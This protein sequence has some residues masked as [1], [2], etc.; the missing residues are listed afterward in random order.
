MALS[1]RQFERQIV[2]CGIMT[3]DALSSIATHD[4]DPENLVT[5]LGPT[6]VA[7]WRGYSRGLKY[8][9]AWFDPPAKFAVDA[10]TLLLFDCSAGRG[11]TLE[12]ASAND[13]RGTIHGA[14]WRSSAGGPAD[15]AEGP[16]ASSANS[17]FL[18]NSAPTMAIS[19]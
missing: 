8:T 1:V 11:T 10:D 19:R 2:H 17:N 6:W 3:A 9:G 16:S 15:R 7:L 12:D 5:W 4:H 13:N 14:T 18:K